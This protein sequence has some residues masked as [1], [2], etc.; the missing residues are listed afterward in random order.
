MVDLN[1]FPRIRQNRI[2]NCIPACIEN[3]VRY[4]KP[5]SM[6][7]WGDQSSI[8]NKLI[9]SAGDASFPI[10]VS[11]LNEIQNDVA[12]ETESFDLGKD[13]EWT[14][15]VDE[16][17]NEEWLPVAYA[18]VLDNPIH[19]HVRVIL[20]FDGSEFEVFDPGPGTINRIAKGLVL[21]DINRNGLDQGGVH[22]GP[23]RDI[24]IIRSA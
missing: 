11:V 15:R 5:L 24:L 1:L 4:H 2:D 14:A 8:R 20:G 21:E 22:R 7:G 17:V 6:P 12:L 9:Q 19:M 13:D 3:I 16:L 23:C 10:A 18:S